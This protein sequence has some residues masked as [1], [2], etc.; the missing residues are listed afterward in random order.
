MV[1]TA[2]RRI[3]AELHRALADPGV[4]VVAQSRSPG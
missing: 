4:K 2:G 1:D 3:S